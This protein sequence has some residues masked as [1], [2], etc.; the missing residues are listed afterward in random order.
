MVDA[1]AVPAQRPLRNNS[2]QEPPRLAAHRYDAPGA[3]VIR[4]K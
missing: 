3:V 4:L 1:P 2:A